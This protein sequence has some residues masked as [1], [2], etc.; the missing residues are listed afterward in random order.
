MSVTVGRPARNALARRTVPRGALPRTIKPTPLATTELPT[1]RLYAGCSGAA[2][3]TGA[4]GAPGRPI[5][6][7][8]RGPGFLSGRCGS[9][10]CNHGQPH[11]NIPGNHVRE[12]GLCSY[13]RA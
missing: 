1:C 12:G 8:G 7:S 9:Q 3:G 10:R 6:A 5:C 13:R 4:G 2:E 11:R